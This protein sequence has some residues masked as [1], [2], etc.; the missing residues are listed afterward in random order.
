M[1][2]KSGDKFDRNEQL[3]IL[4]EGREED[5]VKHV[6]LRILISYFPDNILI[7]ILTSVQ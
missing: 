2:N 7:I 4:F 6:K 1:Y 3:T 5:A